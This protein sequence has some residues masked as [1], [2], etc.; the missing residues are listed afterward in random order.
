MNRDLCYLNAVELGTLLRKLQSGEDF[1]KL[2]M[3]YSE[4]PD[5]AGSGGD[6]GFIPETSL[7][8]DKQAF[9][10]ISV[11]KPGEYTAALPA[12][13]PQTGAPR[14]PPGRD[15]AHHRARAIDTAMPAVSR[16]S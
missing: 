10:A 1:A 9:A 16:A 3:N 4:Q 7:K 5:T 13:D 2:A 8:E 11:L 12:G 14:L 6:L 15:R